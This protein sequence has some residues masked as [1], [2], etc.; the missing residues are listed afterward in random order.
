MEGLEVMRCVKST[1][2]VLITLLA[3]CGKP[4]GPH[5]VIEKPVVV[6]VGVNKG[7]PTDEEY[8]RLVALRPVRLQDQPAPKAD[9]NDP[10]GEQKVRA[11]RVM[12]MSAQ[13]GKYEA[14]GGLTD[15]L[16]SALSNCKAPAKITP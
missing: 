8:N 14:E 10:E 6:E 1:S 12:R 3:A 11:E 4:N 13:L 7:C 16:F 9:P 2:L 15:Q 5:P